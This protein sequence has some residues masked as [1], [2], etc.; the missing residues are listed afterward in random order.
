MTQEPWLGMGPFPGSPGEQRRVHQPEV[1]T[2]SGLKDARETTPGDKRRKEQKGTRSAKEGARGPNEG[3]KLGI[4][5]EPAR[6]QSERRSQAEHG[7]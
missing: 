2:T 5:G 6:R 4:A 1:S 3:E 7:E